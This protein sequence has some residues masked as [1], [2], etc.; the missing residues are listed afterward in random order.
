M[1]LGAGDSLLCV[2][3]D[4]S[5][6]FYRAE[7]PDL[8]SY[9]FC[10]RY[11]FGFPPGFKPHLI[12]ARVG[13]ED[14][15]YHCREG[16]HPVDCTELYLRV[17]KMLAELG[18]EL[19]GKVV[20]LGA[21]VPGNGTSFDAFAHQEVTMMSNPADSETTVRRKIDDALARFFVVACRDHQVAYWNA[22][23]Q[24]AVNVIT[25]I[26]N[27]NSPSGTGHPGDEE[28]FLNAALTFNAIIQ[29]R[30]GFCSKFLFICTVFFF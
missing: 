28:F 10:Y 20:F 5:F 19:G 29:V 22:D 26:P 27:G 21:G 6:V 8:S 9:N 18:Q 2:D 30:A 12:A 7:F 1:N 4:L 13:T 11:H 16:A 3:W 23:D 17:R 15:K 14:I 25:M 24:V